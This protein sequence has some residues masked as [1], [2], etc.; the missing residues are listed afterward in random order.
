MFVLVVT[1]LLVAL[2]AWL[3]ARRQPQPLVFAG[4]RQQFDADADALRTI[5][6]R[7]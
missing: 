6:A 7:A 4:L 3:A 5:G 1:A 2:A